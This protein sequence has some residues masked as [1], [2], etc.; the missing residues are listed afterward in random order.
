MT[1][2]VRFSPRTDPVPV[3]QEAGR[4]Q[5]LVRTTVEYLTP[6]IIRPLVRPAIASRY[7]NRMGFNEISAASGHVS[8][9]LKM[10][11]R[12]MPRR[13]MIVIYADNYIK[14]IHI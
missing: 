8:V 13:K 10:T 11:K 3:V 12:I 1:R 4:A 2:S 9:C 5:W 14:Y 7:V 6:T